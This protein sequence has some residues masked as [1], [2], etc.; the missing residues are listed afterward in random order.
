MMGQQSISNRLTVNWKRPRGRERP[1]GRI[2]PYRWSD[3]KEKAIDPAWAKKNVIYRWSRGSTGQVAYVGETSGS[4]DK[5]ANQ[6]QCAKPGSEGQLTNKK[7]YQ[8]QLH[9]LRSGD[10]L[11]LEFT[12]KV[13]GYNLHDKRDR[14]FAEHLLIGCTRPYLQ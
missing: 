3:R 4:L 6:Y 8:E 9:L 12:D 7:V 1:G 11:Y 5:R 13:Q 2:R 14:R 10:F